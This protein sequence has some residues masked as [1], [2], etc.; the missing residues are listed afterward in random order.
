[1]HKELDLLVN[2]F[3]SD[4]EKTTNLFVTERDL[5]L[6]QMTQI[7]QSMNQKLNMF[8]QIIEKT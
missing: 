7:Q 1:M 2:Q 4:I 6:L 5:I 3:K 8:G